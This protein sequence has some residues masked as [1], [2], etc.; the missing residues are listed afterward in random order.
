LPQQLTN[1]RYARSGI[2][3]RVLEALEHRS[4][5]GSAVVVTICQDLQEHV[6]AMGAGDRAVLIENVM[7]G[8][9]EDPPAI[10]AAD[11]RRRWKIDSS[12]PVVLYTGTFEAY[13]GLELLLDA[14]GIVARTY[15][16]VRL[17]VVGGQPDQVEVA[18]SRATRAGAPAVFSGHQPARDIPAFVEAAD[19]LASPRTSGTNTPLKI[20]SYLRS[21]KPIVATDLL[22]HTQVLDRDTALLAAPE[23]EAFAAALVR[24]IAEPGLGAQLARSAAERART[25]YSRDAYVARTKHVC[26]RVI[27]ATGGA[28]MATVPPT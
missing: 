12:A 8:D 6:T 19:I 20:Y 27:A 10:T 15:P 28:R 18:R 17:L 7:G 9:V 4:V 11:V 14:L 23:A 3:R 2:L 22:T 21:G 1:F 13:Q 5:F 26:E 16:D 25:R 24:L